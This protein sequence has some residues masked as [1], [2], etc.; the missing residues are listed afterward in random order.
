MSWTASFAIILFAAVF[1]MTARPHAHVPHARVIVG[2]SENE[3][4]AMEK[5]KRTTV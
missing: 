1:T 4:L 2:L 5:S 3:T